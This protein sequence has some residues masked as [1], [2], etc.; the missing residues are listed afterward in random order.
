MPALSDHFAA[1]ELLEAR[2]LLICFITEITREARVVKTTEREDGAPF[3]LLMMAFSLFLFYLYK[4]FIF[5]HTT[6]EPV[7]A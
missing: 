1:A 4:E 5:P 2:A 7:G 6:E 3:V